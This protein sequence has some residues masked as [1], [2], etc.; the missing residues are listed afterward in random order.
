MFG[1]LKSW[2]SFSFWFNPTPSVDFKFK[3][4]LLIFSICL[5]IFSFLYLT[6]F[7]F[8]FK[9][10][11]AY[12]ILREH[13]FYFFFTISL[14]LLLGW[15]FRSEGIIYLGAPVVFLGIGLI[16]FGWLIYLIIIIFKVFLPILREEK[17]WQR[18]SKYLPRRR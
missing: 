7:Y 4:P 5:M 10:S 14:L 6:A 15:F 2:K 16:A 13:L 17:D 1:F 11:K 8:L 9:N 12:S 18:K 3:K